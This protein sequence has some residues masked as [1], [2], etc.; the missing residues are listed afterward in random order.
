M[1][2]RSS[3]ELNIE[4]EVRM[5]AKFWSTSV[6]LYLKSNW[7]WVNFCCWSQVLDH[8]CISSQIECEWTFA[9]F[10]FWNSVPQLKFGDSI[11]RIKADFFSAFTTFSDCFWR[12]GS[13]QTRRT[14]YLRK[15]RVIVNTQ[16]SSQN[17]S[18]INN[19]GCRLEYL[20][21]I[22]LIY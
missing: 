7:M 16:E 19:I 10:C 20:W 3:R 9:Q 14:P 5:P 11:K 4:R 17:I 12:E 18:A 1:S 8:L 2:F 22:G 21:I 15:T 6:S 13:K